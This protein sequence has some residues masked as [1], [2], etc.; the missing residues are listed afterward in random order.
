MDDSASPGHKFGKYLQADRKR[1]VRTRKSENNAKY[2]WKFESCVDLILK[3]RMSLTGSN[4]GC[5][6]F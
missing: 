5:L 3:F 6:L 4:S 1:G 2:L